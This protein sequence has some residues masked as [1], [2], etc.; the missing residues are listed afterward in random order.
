[1]LGRSVG[2]DPSPP[3]H[4][5]GRAEGSWLTSALGFSLDYFYPTAEKTVP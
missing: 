3:A 4:M 5:A 1:M 2:A